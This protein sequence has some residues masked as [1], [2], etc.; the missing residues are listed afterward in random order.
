MERDVNINLTGQNLLNLLSCFLYSQT[1]CP[2]STLRFVV[3]NSLY[4]NQIVPNS[5]G[6]RCGIH[7]VFYRSYPDD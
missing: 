6:L 2:E 1:T 7:D 3:T 5:A 4:K